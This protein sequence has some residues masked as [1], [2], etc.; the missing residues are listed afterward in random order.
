M[1]ERTPEPLDEDDLIRRRARPQTQGQADRDDGRCVRTLAFARP[2][3]VRAVRPAGDVAG[4][5]SGLID[6]GLG[7]RYG[8]GKRLVAWGG[9]L[10]R[11]PCGE[12]FAAYDVALTG[13][14]E[15]LIAAVFSAPSNFRT[16]ETSCISLARAF[17]HSRSS[18]VCSVRRRSQ[19]CTS[20]GRP[21]VSRIR[22]LSS[23]WPPSVGRVCAAR[24]E[25]RRCA[26]S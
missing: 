15:S 24:S 19:R 2:A 13:G 6:G 4:P 23:S 16:P 7:A 3:Q 11:W 17:S 12:L 1:A 20:R 21:G 25:A 8:R 9:Q 18:S 10:R 26:L 22:R 5:P 14:C